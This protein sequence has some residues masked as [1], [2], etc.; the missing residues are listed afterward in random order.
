MKLF[1][2]LVGAAGLA[3]CLAGAWL[4]Y[5]TLRFALGPEYAPLHGWGLDDGHGLGIFAPALLL[6]G[7][8]VVLGRFAR[9]LWSA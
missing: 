3:A 1:A 5:R 7:L 2:A 9:R 6:V 8:G 4:A